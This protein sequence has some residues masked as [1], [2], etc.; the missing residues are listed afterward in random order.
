MISILYHH[1]LI[2]IRFVCLV[3]VNVILNYYSTCVCYGYPLVTLFCLSRSVCLPKFL[4]KIIPGWP[5]SWRRGRTSRIS[6]PSLPRRSCWD[7]STT[8]WSRLVAHAGWITSVETLRWVR[9]GGREGRRK[10]ERGRERGREKASFIVSLLLSQC[11]TRNAI[12]TSST[13]LPLKSATWIYLPYERRI[14]RIEQF[15]CWNRQTRWAAESLLDLKWDIM[16]IL[17][18]SLSLSLTT[19]SI[20]HSLAYYRLFWFPSSLSPCRM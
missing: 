10:G 19:P 5:A 6:W 15:S 18:S 8:I 11:R 9:E 17:T 7:G 14:L 12:L 1:E 3:C 2:S 4:F 13:K 20:T 16:D